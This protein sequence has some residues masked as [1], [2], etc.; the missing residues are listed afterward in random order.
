MAVKSHIF[1]NTYQLGPCHR[2]LPSVI[3]KNIA[4]AQQT[5]FGDMDKYNFEKCRNYLLKTVDLVRLQLKTESKL[6]R[7]KIIVTGFVGTS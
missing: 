6:E 1:D 7:F 2:V 3:R 4:F 5:I